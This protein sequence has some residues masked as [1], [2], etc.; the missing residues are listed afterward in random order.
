MGLQFPQKGSR[1]INSQQGGSA[2]RAGVQP[3]PQRFLRWLLHRGGGGNA[4]HNERQ[5]S[6]SCKD[7]FF[8][9][10]ARLGGIAMPRAMLRYIL[11][12]ELRH[13][14][15]MNFVSFGLKWQRDCLY[16]F[17]EA[18]TFGNGGTPINTS[19]SQPYRHI[20][21]TFLVAQLSS[22][23]GAGPG[24]W[25]CGKREPWAHLLHAS[26]LPVLWGQYEAQVQK[27]SRSGGDACE[28]PLRNHLQGWIDADGPW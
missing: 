11:A 10:E 7:N 2:V 25:I 1:A 21:P 5:Q 14:V 26:V 28:N 16:F 19:L 23:L 18:G 4:W 9:I 13:A 24:H 12:S 8:P 20:S 6:P 3:A 22:R 15:G 17:S 27:D